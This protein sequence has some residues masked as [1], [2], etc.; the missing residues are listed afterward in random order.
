MLTF[1]VHLKLKYQNVHDE[2]M[3]VCIN[4]LG[5]QRIHKDLKHDKSRKEEKNTMEINVA[6]INRGTYMTKE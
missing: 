3:T 5:A 1:L 4:L 2:L 6:Y